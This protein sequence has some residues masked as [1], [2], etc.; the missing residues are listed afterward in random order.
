MRYDQ[1][2]KRKTRAK[3]LTAAA[4]AI[5]AEGPE[6]VGV[7][8]VMAE[9]GLTHGGGY[10]HFASKDDLVTAAIAEMFAESRDKFEAAVA[11][12]APAEALASYIDFYVSRRHRD[13]RD[14]GCP[15]TAL[16]ADLP[17][18]TPGAQL[19]FGAGVDGLTSSLAGRLKALGKAN[20]KALAASV[21]SEM[22][23]AVILSRA[24]ADRVQSDAILKTSRAAVKARLGLETNS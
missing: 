14:T 6:R 13:F 1:D 4:R 21:L 17:R 9:A 3:V 22:V 5:R 18:M 11:G 15:L 7:A 20:S 24:I 16:S 2:H 23:G 19:E 12:R 8:D 10:A